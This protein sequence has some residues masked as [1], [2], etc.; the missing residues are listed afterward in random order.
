MLKQI[1][2]FQVFQDLPPLLKEQKNLRR[3]HV[4]GQAF[5]KV[6]F[7]KTQEMTLKTLCMDNLGGPQERFLEKG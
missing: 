7:D 4:A 3:L 6:E 2:A 1:M 5:E